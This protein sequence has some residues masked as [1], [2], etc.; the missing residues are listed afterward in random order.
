[1][2]PI[3]VDETGWLTGL[4]PVV[5]IDPGEGPGRYASAFEQL[6]R[7]GRALAFASFTFDVDEPGSV[8]IA[9]S[10]VSSD[11]AEPVRP[12]GRVDV[13]DDGVDAWRDG[14][15]RAMKAIHGDHVSKVVL[16]RQVKV[17][18]DGE[19]DAASLVARLAAANPGCYCF[20]VA[21]LVGASPELL[22]R[23]RQGRI[24]TLALA[25]TATDPEQLE[26]VKISEEH[27]HVTESVA[28]ALERHLAGIDV[29]EQ[30]I[31]THGR[32]S[33][34]G[35]RIEGPA[36]PG[37][38]V[39]DI[40]ADLHPTAA[41]AG[42]P[43]DEAISLIRDLEPASRGRYAGP[44]GW[45]DSNGEGVF[46]LALRCGQV[47]DGAVTL[48]AGGGLVAGSEEEAELEETELKLAP[49]IEAL[50]QLPS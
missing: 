17:A 30:I 13:L 32:M 7:T 33:H 41:V 34:V 48:F 50:G 16:A 6:R 14:Y 5:D 23:A 47:E 1:M 25:G 11:P 38:T 15:E 2:N 49:M 37:S 10:R 19:L 35:T 8:V 9:P 45:L 31:V 42:A 36:R 40:L 26:S 28:G 20:A 29:T 12:R 27:K 3:W 44:V 39:V 18:V 43:R 22:V 4:G 21:G 24:S 46:A